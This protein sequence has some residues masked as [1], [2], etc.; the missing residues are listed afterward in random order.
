VVKEREEESRFS[1]LSARRELT[2]KSKIC[3]EA[4][5]TSYTLLI[6]SVQAKVYQ[7][8]FLE[9]LLFTSKECR[10]SLSLPFHSRCS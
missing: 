3:L 8:M 7:K 5:C 6:P 10:V 9:L 4:E 2:T 1:F